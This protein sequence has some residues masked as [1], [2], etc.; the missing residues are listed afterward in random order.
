VIGLAVVIFAVVQAWG[1]LASANP[2]PL[3]AYHSWLFSVVVGI[4]GALI[5][6][7]MLRL[8]LFGKLA[9]A[10]T[11]CSGS[12]FREYKG[13]Y[14][15][16]IKALKKGD[17][18]LTWSD[19]SDFRK[20]NVYTS[21][22]LKEGLGL[23]LTQKRGFGLLFPPRVFMINYKDEMEGGSKL[24]DTGCGFRLVLCPVLQFH[25]WKFCLVFSAPS[26]GGII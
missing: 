10:L 2:S 7:E 12:K 21:A 4:L 17:P 24:L 8:I 14:K 20:V 19:L 13:K 23:L 1:Q 16:R 25:F 11:F 18:D 22:F 26:R 3:T 15:D 5:V 6:Y 9:S